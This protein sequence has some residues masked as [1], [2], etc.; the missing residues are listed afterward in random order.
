MLDVPLPLLQNTVP[1]LLHRYKKSKTG[2]NHIKSF[3]KTL[4]QMFTHPIVP[5]SLNYNHQA[6]QFV[7]FSPQQAPGGL[8]AGRLGQGYPQF[9]PNP[10][11]LN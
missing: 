10:S 6:S 8:P 4:T 1:S 5:T 2:K 11:A 7:G 3:L 9:P